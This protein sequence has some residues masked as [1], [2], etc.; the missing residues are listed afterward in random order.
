M[1]DSQEVL[2]K[3]L[4]RQLTTAP[5]LTGDRFGDGLLKEGFYITLSEVNNGRL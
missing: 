3:A 4:F 5:I 1:L 2:F